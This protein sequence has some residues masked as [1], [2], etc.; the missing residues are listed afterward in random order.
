MTKKPAT[1]AFVTCQGWRKWLRAHHATSD[2]IWLRIFKKNSGVESVSYAEAL[3]EALCFGWIDG[4]KNKYDD[5]SWL[6]RFTPR[7]PKSVWSKR[8]REHVERLIQEKRM[9]PAGLAKVDAAKKDGRWDEAYDAQS[10]MAVPR[11]FL[12]ELEKDEDAFA[13][14]KTLNRS[15]TYAI[16][17]RLQNAKKPETRERRKAQLLAL[18]KN[19]K[20]LH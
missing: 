19:G 14:F 1:K 10:T 9:T 18:M 15:N 4:Q 8:N 20:K 17:W 7:R 6:Q 3:D 2:G 13:F 11:D 5:T 16:A 12:S